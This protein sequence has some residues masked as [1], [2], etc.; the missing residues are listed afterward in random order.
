MKVGVA[1]ANIT[2]PVGTYLAGYAGRDG[3]CIGVHDQL[4]SKAI[5]LQ[6]KSKVVALVTNDLCGLEPALDRQIR[7]LIQERT[8]IDS[9]QIIITSTH[10]HSG[11]LTHL[12]PAGMGLPDENY[13]HSLKEKI[14]QAVEQ[15]KKNLVGAKMSAGKGEAKININRRK[16]NSQGKVPGIQPNPTGEVDTEVGVVK[17]VDSKDKALAH[18]VNY[19]C[20]AVVLG[21]DNLSV[22]ADY[23]GVVQSMVEESA[24]GITLFTNGCCGDLNPIIHPGTFSDV[25]KLSQA[26]ASEALKVSEKLC[27]YSTPSLELSNSWV[28]LPLQEPPPQK[29]LEKIIEKERKTLENSSPEDIFTQDVSKIHYNWAQER[30]N[31]IRDNRVRTSVRVHLQTLFLSS[32]VLVAL[33]GEILVGI[34][35]KIKQFSPFKNTFVLGYANG[36]V[37]YLPTKEAFAEGGYE[38]EIAPLIYGLPLFTPAVEETILEAV[39]GMLIG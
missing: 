27:D 3:P 5:V 15:A 23:P 11:P 32:T 24:G 6:D 1:K 22:S 4:Y 36:I 37:G 8:G 31:E 28:D 33:P 29:T 18:I 21:R 13:L 10:T 20:H 39:K 17:L 30:L 12:F 25:S 16:K 2:P 38:V 34:G 26:I 19:A 7:T 14:S 35:K 9:S